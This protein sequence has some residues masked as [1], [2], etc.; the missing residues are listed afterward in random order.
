MF[1]QHTD[2]DV[3][4]KASDLGLNDED[5]MARY[6]ASCY[7]SFTALHLS[8]DRGNFEVVRELLRHKGIEVNGTHSETALMC[9]ARRGYEQVV[10]EFVE[11][12]KV[13]KH[14]INYVYDTGQEGQKTALQIACESGHATTVG[15]L[16][17]HQ[18][19]NVNTL[20]FHGQP[21][22]IN[23]LA[24][25]FG[26]PVTDVRSHFQRKLKTK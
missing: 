20:D 1:Q 5:V 7:G 23:V 4:L 21:L 24:R 26:D 11:C 25:Y 8:S 17:K 3:N 10:K 15:E 13:D 18:N 2:M 9:A 22:L 16:L 12:A 19:V 6:R 14:Y